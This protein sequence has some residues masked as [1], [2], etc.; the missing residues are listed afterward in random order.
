MIDREAAL[1]FRDQLRDA[2]SV[3]LRD[4]ESHHEIAYLIIAVH[5]SLFAVGNR[6]TLASSN[7]L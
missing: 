6:S 3:A 5:K 2:R 1:H 4:S 7:T